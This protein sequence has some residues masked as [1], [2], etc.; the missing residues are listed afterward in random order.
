MNPEAGWY[1]DPAGSELVRYW[2]GTNW[3]EHTSP[4][5]TAAPPA[6]PQQPAYAYAQA[7]SRPGVATAG[8]YP[9]YVI[10]VPAKN[11]LATRALVWAIISLVINPIALPSIMAIVFGSQALGV[12]S[13]MEQAGLPNSARGRAISAIV[14]G[15]VGALIFVILAVYYFTRNG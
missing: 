2:D 7:P 13:Q 9:Q 4:P 8:A 6:P 1:A 15:S 14:V 11:S 3:T 10:A 12:A 5:P